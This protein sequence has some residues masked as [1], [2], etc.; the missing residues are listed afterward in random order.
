M[1]ELPEKPQEK[2]ASP[3]LNFVGLMNDSKSGGLPSHVL[4]VLA[5]YLE[6][7]ECVLGLAVVSKYFYTAI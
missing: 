1:V 7:Y 6:H 3:S 5:Q 2:L 4:C